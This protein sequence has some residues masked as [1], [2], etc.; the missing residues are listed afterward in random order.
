MSIDGLKS[1]KNYKILVI[2]ENAKEG[3]QSTYNSIKSYIL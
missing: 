1:R 3:I 2:V